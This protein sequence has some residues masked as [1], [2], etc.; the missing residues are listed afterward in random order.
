MMRIV[1]V[2]SLL[3]ISIESFALEKIG[4]AVYVKGNVYKLVQENR[5]ILKANDPLFEGDKIETLDKSETKILF[6]NDTVVKIG[7]KSKFNF[8]QFKFKSKNNRKVNFHQLQGKIRLLITKKVKKGHIRLKTH[9]LT[10][11]VR[12][13]EFLTKVYKSK[14]TRKWETLVVVLE[15]ALQLKY[16]DL[17]DPKL[18]TIILKAGQIFNTIKVR[19]DQNLNSVRTLPKHVIIRFEDDTEALLP[20]DEENIELIEDTEVETTTNNNSVISETTDD[21]A[22]NLVET[23]TD[24]IEESDPP[25]DET[26][27]TEQESTITTSEEDAK[28][29]AVDTFNQ[30]FNP[31]PTTTDDGQNT[32]PDPDPD[33]EPTPDPGDPPGEEPPNDPPVTEQPGNWPR[34]WPGGAKA[35]HKWASGWWPKL[36]KIQEDYSQPRRQYPRNITSHRMHKYLQRRTNAHVNKAQK[37]Q[38]KK[39]HKVIEKIIQKMNTYKS[40]PQKE[41]HYKKIYNKY[42]KHR[43]FWKRY[44][45]NKKNRKKK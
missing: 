36:K 33:P 31:E 32:S 19:E 11:G 20:D 1:L 12:G 15:G 6:I 34:S 3:F 5:V 9:A 16:K 29:A 41:S 44:Q 17:K 8:D 30:L 23:T 28:I 43:N 24:I 18:G 22:N 25:S 45:R 7:K 14:R 13:T 27:T 38:Q 37:K 21:S 42:L 39:N 10:M 4:T 2:I 40:S 26:I 35:W